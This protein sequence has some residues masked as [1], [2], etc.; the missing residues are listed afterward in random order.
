MLGRLQ[1]KW[2]TYTRF[3]LSFHHHFA[4]SESF[5]SFELLLL[6][7]SRA[8]LPLYGI[9]KQGLKPIFVQ[10]DEYEHHNRCLVCRN[11]DH[12]KVIVGGSCIGMFYILICCSW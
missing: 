3:W 12:E 10:F 1:E 6:G 4:L 2:Q 8:G 11:G 7:V 5:P 9:L